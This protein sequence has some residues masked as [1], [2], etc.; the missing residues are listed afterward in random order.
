MAKEN[1]SEAIQN[2]SIALRIY[3]EINDFKSLASTHFFLYVVYYSIGDIATSLTH[4]L[5]GLKIAENNKVEDFLEGAVGPATPVFLAEIGLSLSATESSG[6]CPYLCT[7]SNRPKT[8][9][10]WISL[11]LSHLHFGNH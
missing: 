9:F 10:K 5:E 4:L 7:E 11:E 3:S 8:C 6:L 1:Q 2:F